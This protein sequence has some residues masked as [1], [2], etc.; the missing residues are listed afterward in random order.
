MAA[1]VVAAM[2]LISWGLSLLGPAIPS[3]DRETIWIGTVERGP[4]LREIRGYGILIPMEIR[5]IPA[6]TSG[7]VERILV[8]PGERVEPGQPMM[9]LSNPEVE[10]AALNAAS[11]LRRAEAEL[12]SL[13]VQ[14]R[15]EQLNQE[16]QA[17]AV[18]SEYLQAHLKLRADQ[19]LEKEG[20]IKGRWH[21]DSPGR[22]RKSYVLTARGRRYFEQQRQAWSDFFRR[23]TALRPTPSWSAT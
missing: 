23:F 6:A 4:M 8:S 13:D 2:A 9:I 22:K 20:L 12:V 15:S 14:L 17:A 18:E 3:V 21:P 5:W 10:Q 11:A 16:A 7:R 1:A 19:A